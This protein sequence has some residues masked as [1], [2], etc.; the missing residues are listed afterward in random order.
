MASAAVEQAR[1]A[2]RPL[3]FL[4]HERDEWLSRCLEGLG[5]SYDNGAT[6]VQYATA[7]HARP[8]AADAALRL[9]GGRRHHAR[10]PAPR[11]RWHAATVAH[12]AD[13]LASC[14]HYRRDFDLRVLDAAGEVAAYCV[15]WFDAARGIAMF[16]PVRTEDGHQRRGPGARA[17]PGRRAPRP[18]RRRRVDE[19]RRA[20]LERRGLQA[21]RE[22]RFHAGVAQAR[23]SLRAGLNAAHSSLMVNEARN[24][25]VLRRRRSLAGAR[26]DISCPPLGDS[27]ASRGRSG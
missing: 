25:P 14:A 2:E 9:H 18:W 21:L 7:L 20:R 19:G 10:E 5:L 12:I 16:E 13:R 11:I 26:D 8:G 23:V 4:V 3:H 6:I 22:R 27:A 17:H 15:V 24:L 1:A